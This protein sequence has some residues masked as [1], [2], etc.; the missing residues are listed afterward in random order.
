MSGNAN[1]GL[2]IVDIKNTTTEFVFDIINGNVEKIIEA[3]NLKLQT[4]GFVSES[5]E[6]DITVNEMGQVAFTISGQNG[7]DGK[8]IDLAVLDGSITW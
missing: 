1:Y 8:E 6:L 4:D 7:K 2:K 5:E 3:L